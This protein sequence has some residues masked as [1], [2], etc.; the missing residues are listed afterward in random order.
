MG[1]EL[2]LQHSHWP[3]LQDSRRLGSNHRYRH[4]WLISQYFGLNLQARAK[5]KVVPCPK[6]FRHSGDFCTGRGVVRVLIR[7]PTLLGT[8]GCGKETLVTSLPCFIS[9]VRDQVDRESV[10]FARPKGSGF[11][12]LCYRRKRDLRAVVTGLEV[13]TL[14]VTRGSTREHA[15]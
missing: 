11:A 3:L 1:V 10:S 9:S 15:S 6:M 8:G 14:P 5:G 13:V 7:R 12:A 2:N 4:N